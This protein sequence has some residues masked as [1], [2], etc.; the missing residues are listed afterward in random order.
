M[1]WTSSSMEKYGNF[2]HISQNWNIFEIT[3]DWT[4]SSR[5]FK[6]WTFRIKTHISNLKYEKCTL[7]T[8]TQRM[9][10]MVRI[11]RIIVLFETGNQKNNLLDVRRYSNIWYGILNKNLF[12][13]FYI[14]SSSFS[15]GKGR[16]YFFVHV[17]NTVYANIWFNKNWSIAILFFSFWHR[18]FWNIAYFTILNFQWIVGPESR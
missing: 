13:S 17:E 9:R 6:H 15:S 7:H 8:I 5:F 10:I 11:G 12:Q 1:F 16:A 18:G 2:A 3:K 4:L 14:K